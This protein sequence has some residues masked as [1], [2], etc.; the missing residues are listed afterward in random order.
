MDLTHCSKE[1]CNGQVLE[2][3][4]RLPSHR[5]T[6]R[7]FMWNQL[8]A[9][10][11]NRNWNFHANQILTSVGLSEQKITHTRCGLPIDVILSKT[12]SGLSDHESSSWRS[13]LLKSHGDKETSSER[14]E[15]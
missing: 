5:I 9:S 7:V 12:S 8:L 10:N 4:S 2:P 15:I 11:K 1:N 13:E 6:K 14:T 3:S